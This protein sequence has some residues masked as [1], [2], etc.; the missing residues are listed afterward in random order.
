MKSNTNDSVNCKCIALF[1]VVGLI[2]V[3]ASAGEKANRFLNCDS[4]VSSSQV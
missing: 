1:L 3:I 4:Q 2:A